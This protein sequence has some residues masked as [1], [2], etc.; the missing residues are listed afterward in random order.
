MNA[1][2]YGP[3]SNRVM[4]TAEGNFLGRIYIVDFNKERPIASIEIPKLK[5]S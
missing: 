3:D 4:C 2:Y 5:T 1:S